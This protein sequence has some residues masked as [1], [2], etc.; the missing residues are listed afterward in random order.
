MVFM[1]FRLK[2]ELM[3]VFLE[4]SISILSINLFNY[5]SKDK[6]YTNRY[7]GYW[8][9]SKKYI[10]MIKT[11]FCSIQGPFHILVTGLANLYFH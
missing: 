9:Q 11:Y 7:L 6:S 5:I 4:I 1:F 2:V 8:I 3:L 10:L